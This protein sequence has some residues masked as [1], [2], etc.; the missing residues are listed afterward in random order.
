M[1]E[2]PLQVNLEVEEQ[3]QYKLVL[4]ATKDKN[5]TFA[6]PVPVIAQNEFG[7]PV[8]VGSGYIYKED[9]KLFADLF[10]QMKQSVYGMFPFI[11]R[12]ETGLV[13]T[14]GFSSHPNIDAAIPPILP[15][16]Q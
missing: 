11:Q 2:H 5:F 15:P 16:V 9:G 1:N 6:N 13:H 3:H 4:I 14:I 7:N 12:N 10:I 8:Q